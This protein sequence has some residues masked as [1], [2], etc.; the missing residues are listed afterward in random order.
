MQELL[1]RKKR[2]RLFVL[3]APSGTGKT[4]LIHR[5]LTEFASIRV[6]ISCTTRKKRPEEIDGKDYLFLSEIEFIRRRENQEFMESTFL[7]GHYYGTLKKSV[8]EQLDLGYHVFLVIDTEGAKVLREDKNEPTLIFI[9]PPNMAALQERL[10]KRNTE[11]EEDKQIRL[12]QAKKEMQ[13]ACMYD[14]IIVNDEFDVAYDI[15]R[16]IVIAKEYI[17]TTRRLE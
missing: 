3:S 4:T 17:N 15:L 13:C 12:A 5:L 9:M 6:S 10:Q 14:Y 2:G 1:P 11:T 8:E 7:C 16:S